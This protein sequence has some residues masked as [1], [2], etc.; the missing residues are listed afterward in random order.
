MSQGWE[1]EIHE[2]ILA[3]RE[4]YLR[5]ADGSVRSEEFV[6]ANAY[7]TSMVALSTGMGLVTER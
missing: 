6:R 1:L 3:L 5:R 2:Y 4:G 7:A